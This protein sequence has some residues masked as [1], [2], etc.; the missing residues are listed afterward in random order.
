MAFYG[1]LPAEHVVGPG[2][3]RCE[4]G[5]LLLSSP[6]RRMQDVWR[7]RDY[8]FARSKAEV[9]LLAALDYSR[10]KHVVYVAARPPR[11]IFRQIAARLDR[12]IIHIPLGLL[13]PV[14]LKKI[15]V[16]HILFGHD[17]REIAGE[18]VW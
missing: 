12:K 8:A 16:F 9:L 3:C 15:R 17:K 7:D 5:G 13:S 18:Y 4:Y 14:K 11:S 6:P 1:T 10:E 2:I